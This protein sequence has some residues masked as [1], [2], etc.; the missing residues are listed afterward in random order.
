MRRDTTFAI[1]AAGALL[2]A[3]GA[4]AWAGDACSGGY[5]TT[6][7]QAMPTPVTVALAAAPENPRL[8][9]QFVAALQASGARIDAG[10]PMRLTLL[11][12]IATP[13]QGPLQGQVF[14]NFSWGD[15]GGNVIDIAASRLSLTAQVMDTSSYSYV[16]VAS[17]QC[18]IKVR[19]AGALASELGTLIGRTLGQSVPNGTM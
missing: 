18:T 13:Q 15:Q 10:S 7:M 2:A 1:C 4:P 6:A 17:V 19:D 9:A 14:N 11:F 8:A 16:W 3:A 5:S 12:T